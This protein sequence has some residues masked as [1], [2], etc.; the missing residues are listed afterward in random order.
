[1]KLLSATPKHL[2]DAMAS[3]TSLKYLLGLRAFQ[4]PRGKSG[5]VLSLIYLLILF[6][7]FCVAANEQHKFYAHIKLLKLEY[8]LYQLMVYVKA[9][10]VTCEMV[11]SW[12][13]TKRLNDCYRKIAQVDETLRQLGSMFSYREIYFLTIGIII[14]WFL[15]NGILSIVL[16]LQLCV[17]TETTSWLMMDQIYGINISFIVVLEFTIFVKCLQMK[18]KLVNELLSEGAALSTTEG[19]K[20]G[21]FA[22]EDYANMMDAK[23]HKHI[24]SIKVLS[25]VNRQLQSRIRSSILKKR[26]AVK[27]RTQSRLPSQLQKQFQMELQSQSGSQTGDNSIRRSVINAGCQQRRHL[28]QTIKQVHLELCRVSKTL[29]SNFGMQIAS[30]IAISIMYITGSLYNLY[31]HF[32][33]QKTNYNNSFLDEASV[34]ITMGIIEVVKII[35]ITR[36]CKNATNEGKKTTEIIHAIYKFCED[37]EIQEEIQQFGLQISQSP[38]NFFA[39]GISLNYQVLSTCLKTVT[40][41]LVIMIQVSNSLESSKNIRETNY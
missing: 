15:Y 5:T 40:T 16:I 4:Y 24:L 21:L 12:F 3:L 32:M 31:I 27:S 36:V 9:F 19:M 26:N 2:S 7:I 14:I 13:Y 8:V 6:C 10:F 34:V 39:F 41:Y 22:A 28:L 30:E 11:L 25:Q 1:M 17:D 38:V 35:F 29:C 20:L 18:F 33:Q 23:Q 37:I